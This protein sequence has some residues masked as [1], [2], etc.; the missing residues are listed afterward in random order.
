MGLID[1]AW[2]KKNN[3]GIYQALQNWQVEGEHLPAASPGLCQDG[4]GC[5]LTPACAT[6]G[7]HDYYYLR[8]TR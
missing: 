2:K 1:G 3:S 6:A 4:A 7:Q 5:L 8:C